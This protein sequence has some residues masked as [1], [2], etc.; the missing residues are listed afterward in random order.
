ML[1]FQSPRKSP[2]KQIARRNL[3]A[4]FGAKERHDHFSTKADQS[5]VRNCSHQDQV[6]SM[7]LLQQCPAADGS[8]GKWMMVEQ[9]KRI[10]GLCVVWLDNSNHTLMSSIFA[11][12]L[13]GR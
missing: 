1:I 6:D 11:Q 7:T 12:A 10:L 3:G 4:N 5:S 13:I 8:C 2:G 9:R